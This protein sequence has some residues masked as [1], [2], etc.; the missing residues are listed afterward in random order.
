MTSLPKS[1]KKVE[2]EEILQP[3]DNGNVVQQGWSP[4]CEKEP[5]DLNE[6]GVLKTTAIQDG[7]FLPDENKKLPKSLEPKPAIEVI[8][9]DILMTCAG[10]RN[11][12]GITCFIKSTRHKLMMSG[13]MY[14]FRASPQ[15]VDP[16]YLEFFLLSQDAKVAI[17]KMKTGINDSGLNLTHSRFLRLPIPLAPLNEQKRIVLKIEELFSE[18][19]NA[20]RCLCVSEETLKAFYQSA[21]DHAF[22]GC[23]EHK[24]LETLLSQKLSNGYSGKPVNHKT[25]YR[26]L[27]LSA[28]TSGEFLDQHF[29]YLDE[30]GL[31]DRDIW[32]AP[33]DILIQRGNTIEY[34]GV[35]AL[36][37]GKPN[38]FIFPDLMIRARADEEIIDSRYLYYALSSPKIRNYLRKNAK[39]SAGTMPKINQTIL[40]ATPI[41][42]CPSDEQKKVVQEIERQLSISAVLQKQA[43]LYIAQAK[44]LRQSILKKAFSGQ[45]VAQ[46]PND[47]PASVLLERIRAEKE[48]SK[49]SSKKPKERRRSA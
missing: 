13:K 19:E 43:E 34:V 26:V 1:W 28:T 2:I 14:R 35:P 18:L 25:K 30:N 42:Y 16:K 36:Y 44:I 27:S 41:P 20:T 38:A 4:Q 45:L 33:N 9:G 10:P 8:A 17:D 46:D 5:A 3:L 23:K 40:S 29:K 39:G 31:E 21:L 48:V 49:T 11:R 32:C 15:K 37:K 7:Y 47:E 24:N 22:N 6:W 12:C